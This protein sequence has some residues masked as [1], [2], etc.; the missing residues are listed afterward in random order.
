VHIRKIAFDPPGAD[1]GSN[2][3]LNKELV[4][5]MNEGT[6]P[7]VITG[8]TLRDREAH[9]YRFPTFTLRAGARV[10]VHNGQGSNNAGNLYWD[11]DGYVWNN[12]GDGATLRRRNGSRVDACSYSGSGSAATC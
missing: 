2:A 6:S 5:I 8:W 9:M 3:S 11:S 1:N 7:V 12:D 10:T 4:V